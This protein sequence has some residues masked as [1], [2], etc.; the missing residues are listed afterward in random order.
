MSCAAGNTDVVLFLLRNGADPR[1]PS[2]TGQTCLHHLQAFPNGDIEK[3]ATALLKAG[4]DIEA[5]DH[6]QHNTPLH[7]AC[8]QARGPAAAVAV[9]VL[10]RYGADPCSVARDGRSPTD[11][12]AMRLR[13]DLL[14]ALLQSS[15]FSGAEGTLRKSQA[16]AQAL[17]ALIMQLK[18]QRLRYG[19]LQFEDHLENVLNILVSTS[20]L[21]A[22]VKAHA[23]GHHP[24]QDACIW[25]SADMIEPLLSHPDIEVNPAFREGLSYRVGMV[26]LFDAIRTRDMNLFR[27]FLSAGADIT[28][29]DEQNRNVLHIVA[30]F[31]PSLIDETIT[32]LSDLGSD[33]SD[34]VNSGATGTGFTPFDMAVQS[35]HFDCARVLFKHGAKYDNFTRPGMAGEY[36][37]SFQYA[38]G[39]QTQLSFLLGLEGTRKNHGLVVCDNGFT[40]FHLAAASFDNALLETDPSSA[41]ITTFLLRHTATVED[42]NQVCHQGSTPLHVAAYFGNTAVARMLLDQA[43]ADVNA[44]T[45]TGATPFDH[46]IARDQGQGTDQDEI[47]RVDDLEKRTWKRRTEEM[48]DL[49]RSYGGLGGRELESTRARQGSRTEV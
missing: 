43:G 47:K 6:D 31:M 1:M 11:I 13:P 14:H 44:R 4:A 15:K 30:E 20:T 45:R 25:G 18:T 3:I 29:R 8:L 12:A 38:A 23:K 35:E 40:L 5:K 36:Y 17:S 19:G 34:L 9:Q 33:L 21:A 27:A 26:P 16:K 7:S 41:D 42:A 32:R 22:Y 28:A 2:E 49:L 39:S 48:R 46:L 24:L 37:N 10:L